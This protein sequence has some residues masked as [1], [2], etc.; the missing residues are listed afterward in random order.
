[1]LAAITDQ[2]WLD[3]ATEEFVTSYAS[4]V[5][6]L[7][8]D[9]Y[10]SQEFPG[11][12]LY[13]EFYKT[14]GTVAMDDLLQLTMEPGWTHCYFIYSHNDSSAWEEDTYRVVICMED[15][16]VLIDQSITVG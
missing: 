8:Y 1:V 6:S 12:V 7:Q 11:L 3:E 13:C 2:G 10:F 9:I 16:T 14:N 15:G 4:G 5:T